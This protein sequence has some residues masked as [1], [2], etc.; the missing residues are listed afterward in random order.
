MSLSLENLK[1]N[2]DH[3]CFKPNLNAFD[4]A[5]ATKREDLPEEKQYK[6]MYGSE[7]DMLFQKDQ[8]PISL[9]KLN[10]LAGTKSIRGLTGATGSQGFS[11]PTG[12]QGATGSLG[13]LRYK[14]PTDHSIPTEFDSYLRSKKDS[15]SERSFIE[16]VADYGDGFTLTT[17]VGKIRGRY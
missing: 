4:T 8:N 17:R 11:G 3:G 6:S 12:V 9:N 5:Q 15:S 13:A 16:K 2:T 7:K 10:G 1:V 14:N